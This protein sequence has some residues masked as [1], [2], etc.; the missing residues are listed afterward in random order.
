MRRGAGGG[1]QEGAG[2]SGK[3]TRALGKAIKQLFPEAPKSSVPVGG[4]PLWGGC[5]SRPQ[6]L[7]FAFSPAAPLA[8][9]PPL[10]RPSRPLP[11]QFPLP[12]S[13]IPHDILLADSRSSLHIASGKPLAPG[14]DTR[15]AHTAPCATCAHIALD[16]AIVL[17]PLDHEFLETWE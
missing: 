7:L 17:A 2:A 1:Q 15:S 10:A 5:N 9:V 16:F 13:L 14:W 3:H 4:S 8:A 11:I 6:L 12:G